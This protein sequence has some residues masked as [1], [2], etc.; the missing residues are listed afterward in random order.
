M[1]LTKKIIAI[2]FAIIILLFLIQSKSEAATSDL[3]YIGDSRTVGMYI[4]VTGINVSSGYISTTDA[5]GVVW[6]AYGG[7]GYD[8]FSTSALANVDGKITSGKKVFILMGANDL[9][10]IQTA[11]DNYSRLINQK[12]AEWKQ[13]GASTFFVSVNP[14]YDAGA[15]GNYTVRN[16][17]VATFNSLIRPKLSSDV[18]YVDTYTKVLPYVAD[19]TDGLHYWGNGG[20]VYSLIYNYTSEVAAGTRSPGG[21]GHHHEEEE[22]EDPNN[23]SGQLV[24]NDTDYLYYKVTIPEEKEAG[25]DTTIK[26]HRV[27]S[28]DEETGEY[29]LTYLGYY[30]YEKDTTKDVRLKFVTESGDTYTYKFVQDEYAGDYYELE[31]DSAPEYI[32]KKLTQ[33]N[34]VHK[35]LIKGVNVEKKHYNIEDIIFNR[36]PIFDVNV[37]SETAGGEPIVDDSLVQTIRNIVAGWYVAFMDLSLISMVLVLIYTG[38]RMA[39]STVA[40]SQ[41]NYKE[42]LI[43]WVKALVMLVFLHVII[44]CVLTVSDKLVEIFAD[45]FD[46]M[47][48]ISMYD[49][50]KTRAYDI[51]FNIGFTATIMYIVLVFLWA[52]FIVAYF[53]R[54]FAVI[55]L[56]AIA[57][58]VTLKYAI[59]GAGG[60]KSRTF[61]SWL[62]RFITNVALQPIHALAYTALIGIAIQLS[63]ESVYGFILA[64]FFMHLVLEADDIMFNIFKFDDSASKF[65]LPP[66]PRKK[67]EAIFISY[68][69]SKKLFEGGLGL[70]RYAAGTIDLESLYDEGKLGFIGDTYRRAREVELEALEDL[71]ERVFENNEKAKDKINTTLMLKR[72]ALQLGV[73]RAA[74]KQLRLRR[75]RRKKKFKATKKLITS[76]G[77]ASATAAYAIP[78][79]V[80]DPKIGLGMIGKYP[81]DTVKAIDEHK[82]LYKSDKKNAKKLAKNAETI[83]KSDKELEAMKEEVQAEERK[84]IAGRGEEVRTIKTEAELR[85]EGEN[86]KAIKQMLKQVNEARINAAT[87]KTRMDQYMRKNEIKKLDS[88]T[89]PEAIRVAIGDSRLEQ[90]QKDAVTAQVLSTINLRG[91]IDIDHIS[92]EISTVATREFTGNKYLRAASK[93]NKAKDLRGTLQTEESGISQINRYINSL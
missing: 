12:A 65:K 17:Q 58:F 8:W 55:T 7:R 41:A 49:T 38:I 30:A 35:V 87:F 54:T 50:I 19:A 34:P 81:G 66:N 48:T 29:N 3:V 31:D 16:N 84:D 90:V 76:L 26:V 78:S 59:E 23:P 75:E 10:N 28:H 88:T 60:K 37:F 93:L 62:R 44:Y 13:R 18:T 45:A 85:E 63:T 33:D 80:I 43:S 46:G 20:R 52:R 14:V 86:K 72:S 67:F 68:A 79:M 15:V 40:E 42:M 2:A 22:P 92:E 5:N 61:N 11:T 4:K 89:A 69:L 21:T 27:N 25:F 36:V 64:L 91:D 39:M 82:K 47:S 71:N 83:K 77:M 24:L 51:R 32:I 1:K 70:E 56:I 57:P 73:G 6:E 9:G 53:R 74:R